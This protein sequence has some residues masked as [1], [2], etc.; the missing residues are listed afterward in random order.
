MLPRINMSFNFHPE[1]SQE[2]KTRM[3]LRSG[4]NPPFAAA[5]RDGTSTPLKAR[6]VSVK[7]LRASACDDFPA[8]RGRALRGGGG[9]FFALGGP[10]HPLRKPEILVRKSSLPSTNDWR[11]MPKEGRLLNGNTLPHFSPATLMKNPTRP[12]Q[13]SRTLLEGEEVCVPA[14]PTNLVQLSPEELRGLVHQ[15]QVYQIE[16]EMQNE[17]LRRTQVELTQSRDRFN[18]L[19]DYAPV[20]YVTLDPDGTMVEANLALATMLGVERGKLVGRNLTCFLCHDTHDTFYQHQRAVFGSDRLQACDLRLRRADGQTLVVRVRSNGLRDG[21][22]GAWRTLSAMSDVTSRKEA[23]AALRLSEE[24]LRF[25]LESCHIGA[26]D[27]D[28]ERQTSFR[29]V[30]HDRLFGYA[31]LLPQW[32]VDDF[33]GHV[34]SKDRATVATVVREAITSERA[35][36]HKCRI[37]RTDGKVRWIRLTG[38]PRLDAEGRRRVAGV[39]QDITLHK[40]A[41]AAMVEHAELRAKSEILA[42]K[43]AEVEQARRT[44]EEKAAELAL[45]SRYKSE[46]L[47]NMSHELRTPLNSILILSQQLAANKVGNLTGKQVEFSQHIHSSGEDLLDLI[48]DIL[49]LSK[50]ES[51]TVSVAVKE[52]AFSHLRDMTERNV[53]HLAEAKNLPFELVFAEGLPPAMASDPKR[54]QQILKNLLSNAVKF[55]ARGKVSL[56]VDLS[57]QGWSP[58][59]PVLSKALQVVGFAIEDTGIGIAVEKQRIIFEAFQQVDA[60]TARNYGGTG[61]GLAISRE[62]AALLGGEITLASVHGEGS[63]FTLYLPIHYPGYAG[64]QDAAAAPLAPTVPQAAHPESAVQPDRIRHPYASGPTLRGRKVLVVDDDGRNI[65]ALTSVFEDHEMDVLTATT[66]RRAIELI[67]HTPD[68]DLVLMDIMMPGMDGY[69]TM[70]EIRRAP[71][72]RTLP[73]F[74]LTAK[75]MKGDREK[76]LDAGASDYIAKPVNTEQLLSLMREWLFR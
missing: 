37:R 18:Q 58:G 45:T 63:T 10:G 69:E 52:I 19:Y 66:G 48:E 59:H 5:L 14:A 72:F 4:K 8:A 46:F 21:V 65:F 76:C 71:E 39:V 2:M 23:E 75:A 3:S 36:S 24:R 74:A 43:N 33:L 28:V 49:D 17:K 57:V 1:I 50:I 9:A 53:R 38:E 47:A 7:A 61:L 62:L 35:W 26:W 54:L 68:L 16:L 6:R 42:E 22:S 64:E 51:G 20:G 11:V 41:E 31:E 30:E 67:Q 13:P 44:L 34:L 70:R 55:T 32:T 73:I 60:G 12:A 40:R 27:F 25:A 15:F 56:R 29:S